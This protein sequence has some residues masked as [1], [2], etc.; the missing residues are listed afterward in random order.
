MPLLVREVL[1]Q[2]IRRKSPV[3]DVVYFYGAPE[4]TAAVI[5]TLV[6]GCEACGKITVRKNRDYLYLVTP[7]AEKAPKCDLF[8]FEGIDAV[9][10][11]ECAEQVLYGLLD[12]CLEGDIQ[13]VITGSAPVTQRL[14]PRIRAQ[15]DG[16]II[17]R[18]I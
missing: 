6:E 7:G 8:I 9:A 18:V 17:C 15:I 3:Y 11:C 2:I 12:G 14:A 4:A 16:G 1:Q 13:I 10:G 5:D